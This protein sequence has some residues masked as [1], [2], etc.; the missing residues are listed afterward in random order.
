MPFANM[1]AD[2]DNEHFCDGLAEELLN[3]LSK[4]DTLRVAARTSL[5]RSRTSTVDVSHHRE[6]ALGVS[7][8]ARG[9]HPAIGQP[10]AHLRATG[11]R[12]RWLSGVVG[13]LRPG[14]PRMSSTS[15]MRSPWL[16][17]QALKLQLFG[18][19]NGAAGTEALHRQRRGLRAVSAR[20]ST[21]P[22]EYTA[23]GLATCDR[24]LRKGSR[25]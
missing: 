18:E 10:P 13:A 25:P 9:Q 8:G 16:S 12:R 6:H 22:P 1:S 2:V 3:A 23:A 17:S 7:G 5:S 4:I 20:G 19:G 21:T 11:Q 15:R 24:L 14:D